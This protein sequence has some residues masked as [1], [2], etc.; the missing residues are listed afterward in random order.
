MAAKK[1]I[2]RRKPRREPVPVRPRQA[3]PPPGEVQ[4]PVQTSSVPKLDARLAACAVRT[5]QE[6]R[7]ILGRLRSGVLISPATES[8]LLRA[9]IA[10]MASGA[11]PRVTR[12]APP[13]GLIVPGSISGMPI[14]LQSVTA[15]MSPTS[16]RDLERTDLIPVLVE[17]SGTDAVR[18]H[19]QALRGHATSVSRSAVIA[20]VPRQQLAELAAH[21]AVK[22]VEA[23]S[24]LKP[25]LDLAH[26]SAALFAGGARAVARTGQGVLIGV[27]DT[28]IDATHPGF[29]NAGKTRVLDYLDQT[30]GRHYTQAQIDAGAAT[31]SPDEDGH[32]THV[33]GIAAGNGEGLPVRRYT[34]VAPEADLAI[35]KT[36]FD[37]ADIALGIAHI[38]DLAARRKQ[39][40]VINLSLG[41][42]FGAHDGSSVIE[43]VI[44]DLCD[45]AGRVVVASAGNEGDT[46]IH[47]STVLPRGSE[48]PSRWVADVE[49]KGRLIDNTLMGLLWLQVWTQ[50][51]DTATVTLRSPNG[52]LFRAPQNGM[53]ETD[54]GKFIVQAAHQIAPYSGDNEFSF[55]IFTVPETRWLSGWSIIVEEDRSGGRQGIEV[56]A[57]HAWIVDEDGGTFRNGFT[58][59]HLVGMP[60]TAFSAITVASYATRGRWDSQDPSM[61][62][63]VLEAVKPDDVSYFSSPGPTRETQNKPDIAAPGQW[64]I[65]A[66]SSQASLEA[67]PAWLR[68]PEGRY[69]ALQ[70]TSMSAPYVTGAI[71]LLFEKESSLHWAEVKRRL[72]KSIRQDRYSRPCWNQRWGFGKLEV[73][74]LLT[75]EPA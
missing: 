66:L 59:S 9:P 74:R 63:V 53:Q 26:S 17:A 51:E 3:P 50:H 72:V 47:A 5:A 18:A 37:T 55:G 6:P 45:H 49:L 28:G 11:M 21:V 65:S 70:G 44:D 52:E 61:P 10:G 36:T 2:R 46:R 12:T 57:V 39:P 33:A 35:V 60:G 56:G 1:P 8:R 40:C 67:I 43:R 32:G 41:G 14:G 19:A 15:Q 62:H 30:T 31:A 64:V 22:R 54:R 13:G 75:I 27:V 48:T 71:A 16:V 4:A 38:F 68:L 24:R 29:Q 42:H 25:H 73:A 23:S 7:S 20:R 69:C 58:K 34:G